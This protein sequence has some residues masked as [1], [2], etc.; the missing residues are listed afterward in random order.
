MQPAGG[1]ASGVDVHHGL[2]RRRGRREGGRKGGREGGR[3]DLL[4]PGARDPRQSHPPCRLSRRGGID[5]EA[6]DGHRES[7]GGGLSVGVAL[8][9]HQEEVYV[10]VL[11]GREGGREG[12]KEGGR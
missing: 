10:V 1:G 8:H 4:R 7:G 12:G 11:S 5:G 6:V 3:L 2:R 9:G